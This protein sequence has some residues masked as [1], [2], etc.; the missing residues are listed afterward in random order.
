MARKSISGSKSGGKTKSSSGSGAKSD[1]LTLRLSPKL[2]YGLELLSR[3]HHRNISSTVTWAIEQA[4]N[5]SEDGLR[6]NMSEGLKVAEPKQMLDVLWDVDP[7][8][9]LVKLANHWPELMDLF[10]EILVRAIKNNGWGWP[11]K[12]DSATEKMRQMWPD[13]EFDSDELVIYHGKL[14]VAKRSG[15]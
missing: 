12:G 6:K 7:A 1:V 15:I 10:D 9:R 3:K 8:D 13:I 4:I 11:K 2:K 14:P 5:N